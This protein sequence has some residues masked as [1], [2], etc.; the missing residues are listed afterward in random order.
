MKNPTGLNRER[1]FPGQTSRDESHAGRDEMNLC[2]LPFALLSERAGKRSVLRFDIRDSD[3]KSGTVIQRTLIVTGDPEFGLPTAKDE[4]IYLGLMKYTSDYNGFASADVTLSRARLFEL[5]GWSKSDWAY[6]RLTLGL[7]R[8]TGVRL[9]YQNLWRDNSQKQWRDQGAFGILDSFHLRD[10]CSSA[11]RGLTC[12]DYGAVFRWSSVLFQSFDSGYLKRIDYGLTRSLSAT[13]RRLYR[14]LDKHFH[15]PHKRF[16]T[17]DLARLAY[18]HIGVCGSVELDKVR[19]RY[20][21]PAAEELEAAGYLSPMEPA[22]RFRKL[23]PGRWLATFER[24]APKSFPALSPQA[25]SRLI[26]AMQRRGVSTEAAQRFEAEYPSE[27]IVRA[28]LAMDE[29]LQ[30]GVVIRCPE[31]WL[32]K[33]IVAGFQPSAAFDRSRLRPERRIFRATRNV[34]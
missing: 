15:L 30:G 3:Q 27:V 6:S 25:Q 7:H 12:E 13:A 33:A 17:L 10:K 19:K 29:Q 1:A 9:N 34:R 18:Q 11:V 8:L 21:I 22:M 24:A 16:L 28:I 32:L 20:I 23:C 4:E 14:Y 2:E 5:M 26:T 31:R